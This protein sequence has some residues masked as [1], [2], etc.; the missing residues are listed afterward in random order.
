MKNKIA[1][2]IAGLLVGGALLGPVV[3]TAQES[4]TLRQRV[5]H[6]EYRLDTACRGL[7]FVEPAWFKYMESQNAC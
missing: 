1:S 5:E 4:Q 7:R 3:A 6:L 2:L